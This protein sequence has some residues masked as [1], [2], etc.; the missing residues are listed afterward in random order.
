VPIFLVTL[1]ALHCGLKICFHPTDK[2]YY[3]MENTAF[4]LTVAAIVF[5]GEFVTDLVLRYLR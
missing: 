4:I 1:L 3:E 2:G 5:L